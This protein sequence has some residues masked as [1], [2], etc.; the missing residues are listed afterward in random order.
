M[1]HVERGVKEKKEKNKRTWRKEKIDVNSATL[2]V[3]LH[4]LKN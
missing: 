1:L 2:Y 3:E 4:Y